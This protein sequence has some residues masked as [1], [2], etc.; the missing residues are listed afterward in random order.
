MENHNGSSA[1]RGGGSLERMVRR[2]REYWNTPTNN[3]GTGAPIED[4]KLKVLKSIDARLEKLE[5]CV[6][7]S[8]HTAWHGP[9]IRTTSKG[10]R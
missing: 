3:P 6:I 9:A 2:L 7:H 1:E 8:D 10:D 5:R 4:E